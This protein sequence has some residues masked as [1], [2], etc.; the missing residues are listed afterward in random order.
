MRAEN[1]GGL[2]QVSTERDAS[3]SQNRRLEFQAM[4]RQYRIFGRALNRRPDLA[5]NEA[6]G[7]LIV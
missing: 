2:T 5:A 7:C 6:V 3:G 4:V 1:A